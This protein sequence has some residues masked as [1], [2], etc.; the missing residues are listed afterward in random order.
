MYNYQSEQDET[1]IQHNIAYGDF[2]D[3][4]RRTGSEK[5]FRDKTFHFS[6]NLKYDGHQWGLP[7]VVYIFLDKSSVHVHASKSAAHTGTWI[8]VGLSPSEKKMFYLLLWNPFTSDGK[9]FLFH[10]K[11]SFH[12][13]GT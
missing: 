7:S 12:S 8:K 3:L 4:L 6:K 5:L 13:E 2:K 1:W 9:C 11:S 10:L